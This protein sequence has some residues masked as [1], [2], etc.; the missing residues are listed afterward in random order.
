MAV[1]AGTGAGAEG[2]CSDGA[3]RWKAAGGREGS[4]HTSAGREEQN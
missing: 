2:V 3:M 1:V 4:G